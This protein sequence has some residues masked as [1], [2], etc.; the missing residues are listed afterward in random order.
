MDY[1]FALITEERKANGLFL[2]GNLTFNT[3]IANLGSYKNGPALSDSKMT[4]ATSDEIKIMHTKC[5]GP[6]DMISALS[7]GN[8]QKVI[9]G[10]W[11]E[12][13]PQI[14]MMDE[15]TRGIDVG[16]KYEIY[17]LI[18]NMAKQGKTVIVVS[19]EMPEILGITNR[20]GVMSNGRLSGIVNTKE[21]NQEELL[22]YYLRQEPA[23]GRHY[24][25]EYGKMLSAQ[26]R[27]KGIL[28]FAIIG[29][30]SCAIDIIT[31]P[32]PIPELPPG[33]PLSASTMIPLPPEVPFEVCIS[34]RVTTRFSGECDF[35]ATVRKKGGG[36]HVFPAILI[37]PGGRSAVTIY[38]LWPEDKHHQGSLIFTN[39]IQSCLLNMD[40]MQMKS[41]NGPA[42]NYPPPSSEDLS[43]ED[44][45]LRL[46][47]VGLYRG[48]S[49]VRGA[50]HSATT[51][52][53]ILKILENM[54][55]RAECLKKPQTG[56]L[57]NP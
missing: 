23:A 3:T 32:F 49:F 9:F 57:P 34:S 42:S 48:L 35:D 33:S 46:E 19:S 39:G 18:I 21:T 28:L 7:G 45:N 15:P 26:L 24:P 40:T 13:G 6:E 11:L 5:M 17:E 25:E 31:F 55:A 44:M 22:S 53:Y 12:R 52:S 50:E 38:R 36:K 1:G 56:T 2:K 8:Q 20:I 29:I 54:Q 14:F 10:K 47:T 30:I 41:L 37:N 43:G 16:A 51:R 4:K 27:N